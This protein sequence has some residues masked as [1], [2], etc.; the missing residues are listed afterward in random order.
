MPLC[1]NSSSDLRR[2]S[3]SRLS[4]TLQRLHQTVDQ[5]RVVATAAESQFETWQQ[6]WSA[7]REQ[8]ARRLELIDMQLEALAR[9][10][11]PRPQ[12]S[13]VREEEHAV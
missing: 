9:E 1:D 6:R 7:H 3:R 12:L 4:E 8:I 2:T 10:H 5:T 11:Q 13:L